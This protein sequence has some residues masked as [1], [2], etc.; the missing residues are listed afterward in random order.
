MYKS[1]ITSAS[2][3]D[4][5][6]LKLRFRHYIGP[7]QETMLACFR[8]GGAGLLFRLWWGVVGEMRAFTDKDPLEK[9]KALIN[10]RMATT[11]HAPGWRRAKK[12]F[13]QFCKNM[14]LPA[15]TLPQL[16]AFQAAGRTQKLGHANVRLLA[17]IILQAYAAHLR[18]KLTMDDI[19]PFCRPA[20]SRHRTW[21][22]CKHALVRMSG[23]PEQT[24]HLFARHW[25]AAA[26][27]VFLAKLREKIERSPYDSYFA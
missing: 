23:C 22:G 12:E 7:L 2:Q 16:P 9:V 27:T 5:L 21:A 8:K 24:V 19:P 10:L 20:R 25:L 4:I 1:K 13:R 18:K 3:Y 26:E 14:Q 17:P 11:Q 15:L 6:F